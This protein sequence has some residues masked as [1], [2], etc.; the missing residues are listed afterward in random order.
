MT[1]QFLITGGAGFIGSNYVARLIERGEAVVVYDNLSR[2]GAQRNVDWLRETYGHKSFQLISKDI[3]SSDDLRQAAAGVDV[4]VHLA[5]Q[6]AVTT[7]VMAPRLDFEINALGTFNVLEAA[8]ASGRKPVV[9]YASTNKVY[10]GMEEVGVVEAETRYCYASLPMGVS[11]AQPLDFHSP[12]GCSKGAGD[13]YVR[14]YCR[15]YDLP[16]VVLRQS[17]IYGPRQFGVEDQGWLAWFVIAAVTGKPVSIYGDGKQVRDVLYVGDLL[18]VYDTCLER[19][20]LASGGIYNIGGGPENTIS[21]WAEF[22]A[23]LEGS[24]GRKLPI[25]KDDWRLGDQRIFVSDI[26]KAERELGWK[27]KVGVQ[28]GLELL[29]EW[30]KVNR[31]LF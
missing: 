21:V 25:R 26:R 29:F 4:I 12:Y 3:R 22:G 18:D 13:Q 19:I 14:D 8:R 27:P 23:M 11:E 6:V 17:C 9:L 2:A 30:V 16:T 1:R 5:A 7:S 28:Q 10:G 15:I 31:H 20:N 24:L